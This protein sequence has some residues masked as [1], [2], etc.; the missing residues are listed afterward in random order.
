MFGMKKFFIFFV[1]LFFFG[2]LIN[3]RIG[4][5]WFLVGFLMFFCK[6]VFVL[7]EECMDGVLFGVIGCIIFSLRLEY[8]LFWIYSRFLVE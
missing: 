4:Y 3:C 8:L 1:E 6:I 5:F 7:V 2:D